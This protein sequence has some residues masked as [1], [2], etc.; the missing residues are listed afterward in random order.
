MTMPIEE[1]QNPAD[2]ADPQAQQKIAAGILSQLGLHPD[3]QGARNLLDMHF[4]GPTAN[5]EV[6]QTLDS[7][8]KPPEQKPSIPPLVNTSSP[9][10]TIEKPIEAPK[11][12]QESS[13]SLISPGTPI[14]PTPSAAS[15]I[16]S[17]TENRT[18]NDQ[19]EMDRLVK[20]GSGIHQIHNPFLRT[21]ATIGDVAGGALFPGVEQLI[22]GTYGHHGMMVN[23]QKNLINTDLNQQKEE[24]GIAQTNQATKNAADEPVRNPN[25]LALWIKEN[26]GKPIEEYWKAKATSDMGKK[27]AAEQV[28]HYFTTP[29]AEGGLGLTAGDA[30]DRMKKIEATN[31]PA[32]AASG[33]IAFQGALAKVFKEGKMSPEVMTDPKAITEVI[34]NSASL[35]PE[36]KDS[37]LAH[38]A[39][40]TTPASQ[41][42]VARIR[43]AMQMTS[44]ITPAIDSTTGALTLVNPQEVNAT[45]GRYIPATQGAQALTKEAGFAE[46]N[47]IVDLTHDSLTGLKTPFSTEQR[48]KMAMALRSPNPASAWDAFF[49]SSVGEALTP[50]Q[51]DYVTA[52]ASLNENAMALRSIQ[53]MGQGSDQLRGA[54][55][56]MLPGA[57]TPSPQ[58]AERQLN[59]IKAMMQTLK[60]GVA[61]T[62][63][64]QP[65]VPKI[66]NTRGTVAPPAGRTFTKSQVQAMADTY[67]MTYEAAKA[68]AIKQGHKVNEGVQ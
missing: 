35:T 59:I 55:H 16:S 3:Q 29:E 26:P 61:H 11:P 43:G 41:G 56:A 42:G 1:V 63:V 22:P 23:N 40:K 31:K 12:A 54:I 34:T 15:R 24:A 19:Y 45:P 47:R 13:N 5:S 44:R 50:D 48:A 66:P 33:E 38:L 64:K 10:I 6:S 68:D 18:L 49:H 20:T 8:G 51:A 2:M 9:E 7:I 4:Q 14:M 52:L 57:G 21:L 17:N 58:Y 30:Y 46:L 32:T 67:H 39:S 28:M 27:T 36:E 37:A 60:G 62:G 53:G 25:E 65:E